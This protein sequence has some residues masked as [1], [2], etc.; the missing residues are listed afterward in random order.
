MKMAKPNVIS[1]E[2]LIKYAMECLVDVGIEKFT[3]KSVAEAA[4]VTQGTVYYH[5]RTKEQLLLHIVQNICERS[6]A[7][8]SQQSTQFKISGAIE[9]AKS[10]CSYDS[11]FHKLFFTLVVSSLNNEKIRSQLGELVLSE[12]DALTKNLSALWPK[13]PIEGVTLETWGIIINAI[14]DGLALQALVRKDFPVEKTYKELEQLFNGL[15]RL[16]A[17]GVE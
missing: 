17:E 12:N 6:W 7:E 4:G 15:N 14:V 16:L 8:I 2:D 5:F 9:S 11:F 10:R 3:L 1:K 13:S